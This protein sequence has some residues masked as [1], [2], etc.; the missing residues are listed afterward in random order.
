MAVVCAIG[1]GTAVALM[2]DFPFPG[3]TC[4]RPLV[5]S[6]LPESMEALLTRFVPEHRIQLLRQFIRFGII[7]TAGLVPDTITVYATRGWLGLYGAGVVAYFVAATF[8]WSLNRA[9]TF[10]GQGSGKAHHQWLRFLAANG[11]GFV[12]NRGTYAILVTVSPLCHDHPVIAIAAGALVS[13]FLNFGLSRRLV[14]R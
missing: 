7:G 4:K 6:N 13:M 11:V 5:P 8:T 3:F 10:R 14:F 9:W 1:K 12:F 2:R